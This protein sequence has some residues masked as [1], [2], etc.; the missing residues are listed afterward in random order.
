MD[1]THDEYEPLTPSTRLGC[2]RGRLEDL[3]KAKAR[4]PHGG[5]DHGAELVA[6]VGRACDELLRI[7]SKLEEALARSSMPCDNCQSASAVFC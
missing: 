5:A 1:G 6:G 3:R 2:V 4:P 7:A